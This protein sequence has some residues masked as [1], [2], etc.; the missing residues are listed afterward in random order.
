MYTVYSYVF[1]LLKKPCGSKHFILLEFQD[2]R[3]EN[4]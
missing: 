4:N 1:I 2:S 3:F